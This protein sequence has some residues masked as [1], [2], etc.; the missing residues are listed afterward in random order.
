MNKRTIVN[1]SVREETKP[2]IKEPRMTKGQ[3]LNAILAG[4][5]GQGVMLEPAYS[6]APPNCIGSRANGMFLN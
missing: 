2:V 4:Y 1:G 5:P 6:A 3:Y